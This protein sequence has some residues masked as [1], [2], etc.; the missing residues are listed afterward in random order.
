MGNGILARPLQWNDSSM[1][2]SLY[3]ISKKQKRGQYSPLFTISSQSWGKVQM[4]YEFYYSIKKNLFFFS[5]PF[6]N[7]TFL[8][9]LWTIMPY[10]F[11]CF[12]DFSVD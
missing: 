8:L 9:L 6:Y 3:K 10:S 7:I 2:V 11:F 4:G 1:P 12:V 5:L